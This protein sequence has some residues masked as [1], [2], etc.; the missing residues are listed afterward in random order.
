M[1]NAAIGIFPLTILVIVG[2]IFFI[3]FF[4]YKRN[5]NK[6][7]NGENTKH[8]RMPGVGTMGSS[9]VTIGV[10]LLIIFN[11]FS[12]NRI[13]NNVYNVRSEYLNDIHNL[14]SDLYNLQ[15]EIKKANSL[16]LSFNMELSSYDLESETATF[17]FQVVPKEFTDNT[18]MSLSFANQVINLTKDAGNTFKGYYD[19]DIFGNE[20]YECILSISDGNT[21]KTETIDDID[22]SCLWVKV[23]PTIDHASFFNDGSYSW[24]KLNVEGF[25]DVYPFSNNGYEFTEAKVHF[26][27]N[28]KT[29]STMD[30][31]I[32][33]DVKLNKE[34]DKSFEIEK[35]DLFEMYIVAK[36]TAGYTHKYFVYS[37]TDDMEGVVSLKGIEDIYDK[38]GN[39]LTLLYE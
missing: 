16:I 28:G 6:A 14:Q 11:L 2:I 12:I 8:I 27:V 29:V 4:F 13:Q 32:K 23:L 20:Y 22:F 10:I 34:I 5:I 39:L 26:D 3:Y 7:L 9:L 37:W 19:V 15:N 38:D 25:L 33:T 18:T 36:D 35:N 24:G 17:E 21:N 31:D 30:L 1:S